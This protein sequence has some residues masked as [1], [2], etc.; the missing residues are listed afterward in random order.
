MF[1]V[2]RYPLLYDFRMK[3]MCFFPR[4]GIR[5]KIK[6]AQYLKTCARGNNTEVFVLL[7]YLLPRVG[8]LQFRF[9]MG[10]GTVFFCGL[11][12]PF[13]S[14]LQT[15][16]N[17]LFCPPPHVQHTILIRPFYLRLAYG[18]QVFACCKNL[19]LKFILRF[20]IKKAPVG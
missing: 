15:R 7:E 19:L 9:A 6:E 8:Y 14:A 4:F 1:A 5:L 13:M 17:S 18:G 16:D 3:V 2:G 12:R 20:H 11:V 10:T